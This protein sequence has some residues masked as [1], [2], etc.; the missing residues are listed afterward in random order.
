M[1]MK[2]RYVM[3]EQYMW[4][5]G[6]YDRYGKLCTLVKETNR[7]F[8]VDQSPLDIL[9]YNIN[10]IGYELQGA[11][12]TAKRLLGRIHHYPILVNP[13]KRIVV[14]P[15]MSP[16]HENCIWFNPAHIKR[17]T[18][19]K[20]HTVILFSNG[21]TITIPSKLSAF[22]NKIKRAEQLEELTR[23]SYFF[24]TNIENGNRLELNL[25]KKM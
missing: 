10:C 13:M 6:Y 4:M 7:T 2:K 23:D 22:N 18:S 14:F 17:T 25:D 1:Y 21:Q 20:Y 8:I 15:T 24:V 11:K 3:N 5:T 9:E 16:H 12:N 19:L